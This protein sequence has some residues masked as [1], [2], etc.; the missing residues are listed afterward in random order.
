MVKLKITTHDR[1]GILANITKLISTNGINIVGADIQT[2]G[3]KRGLIFLKLNIQ[4]IAQLK[5]IHQKLEAQEGVIQVERVV[6]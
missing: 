5:D 4:N 1:T 3:D 6:G 2:T